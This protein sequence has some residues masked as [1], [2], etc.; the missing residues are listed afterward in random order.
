MDY[1]KKSFVIDV[2]QHHIQASVFGLNSVCIV[3]IKRQK[4]LT[5]D[6][7][8]S[9]LFLQHLPHNS[10][11]VWQLHSTLTTLMVW[12]PIMQSASC[13]RQHDNQY[14]GSLVVRIPMICEHWSLMSSN[15][16][17]RPQRFFPGH[18]GLSTFWLE[19]FSVKLWKSSRL[20]DWIF[21]IHIE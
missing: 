14:Y 19:I 8:L 10:L 11:Q 9:Q 15:L 7:F 6:T 5:C 16:V 20:L 3:F 12:V 18:I 21:I 13:H 2:V 17:C 4:V 1:K